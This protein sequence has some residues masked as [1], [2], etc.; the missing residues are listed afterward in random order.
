VT[1]INGKNWKRSDL[2]R[3]VGSPK[4]LGGMTRVHLA[5]GVGQGTSAVEVDTGG[6]L[7]FRIL[8]DR[9]MDITEASYNGLPL[10]WISPMGEAHPARFDPHGAGWLRTFPGGL[11]TTCGLSQTGAPCEDQG[12]ALGV[13]GRY[14][15]LPA[16]E[17]ALRSWWEGDHYHFSVSGL[18]REAVIFGEN[19]ALRRT[20]ACRLG[21]PGFHLR[22][23]VT[24]EGFTSSPHMI[25]YHCNFG[26][27]LIGPA[28]RLLT[29]ARKIVPRDAD[30]SEGSDS[31]CF[32]EEPTPG[33]REKVYFHEMPN[34]DN[35][36]ITVSLNNP[37]LRHGITASLSYS[38][39]SLPY[40]TEW[41]MMGEGT[42]VCGL[43]P[44][45][46]LVMGRAEE[47]RA[48]RLTILEPGEKRDYELSFRV[49]G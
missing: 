16:E 41:K 24:N 22:D 47:R 40:F 28:T 46:A 36:T 14:T 34:T 17:V 45:N 26:F 9:G 12:E 2:L 32:F 25:L 23:E 39:S 8:L 1:K 18:M 13:H 3:W 31:A 35:E 33:Y 27:P 37:E 43:E 7:R 10:A 11:V 44:G 20:I 4:Q 21:E 29:P 15:S 5:E 48:G 42:Y 6:G 30:A 38:A 19:L 49:E